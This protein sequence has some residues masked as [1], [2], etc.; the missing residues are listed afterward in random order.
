[1]KLHSV[2]LLFDIHHRTS[3]GT[4]EQ[5]FLF[6]FSFFL[7]GT[8]GRPFI[9]FFVSHP[10]TEGRNSGTTLNGIKMSFG[11]VENQSREAWWNLLTSFKKHLKQ[12]KGTANKGIESPAKKIYTFNG[13]R[14]LCS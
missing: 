12:K 1:M 10:G 13:F 4:E 7:S 11:D 3:N 6:R 9:P 5:L 8:E 14:T 2:Q